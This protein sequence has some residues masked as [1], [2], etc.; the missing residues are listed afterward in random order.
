MIA[1]NS[2]EVQLTLSV[3]QVE[4]LTMV[5]RLYMDDCGVPKDDDSEP[6]SLILRELNESLDAIPLI[7]FG[8][9]L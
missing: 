1:R 7:S 4:E 2:D 3:F 9:S 8:E 5:L 6:L